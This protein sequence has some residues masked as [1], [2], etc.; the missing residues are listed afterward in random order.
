MQPM[1]RLLLVRGGLTLV[2]AVLAIVAFASGEEL[3]GALMAGLAIT[4]VILITFFV[5]QQ[6]RAPGA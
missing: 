1:Q 6:R 3:F 4:N 5:V 2:A